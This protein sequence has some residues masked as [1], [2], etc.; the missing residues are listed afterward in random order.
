MTR[1]WLGAP[2]LLL[3]L[4]AAAAAQTPDSSARAVAS[5]TAVTQGMVYVGAGRNDGLREGA[6]VTVRRLGDRGRYRVTYL[7]S[8]SAACTPESGAE[9]PVVGDTV[10]FVPAAP[11]AGATGSR[12]GAGPESPARRRG[13]ALRG[14]VGVRYL[15]SADRGAGIGL[16]QPGL[17]LLLEGPVGPGSPVAISVDVRSRRTSTYRPGQPTLSNGLVGVYQAALRV[18]SAR[19]PFRAVLGRQYA[20]TLAG[21]GLFDGVLLD[22]QRPTWGAGVMAGL[23]PEL[24]T[25]A[26]SS[27]VRELG[28]FAQRRSAPGRPVRW[29]LTVGGVGSY[30]RSEVNREFAFLQ[31]TLGTRGVQAVV[32]QEL[33]FNRGWKLEAGESRLAATSTYFSLHLTPARWLSL[34]GGLDNRRN[35]RLYRD[36]TTPEELFDDR[37]RFGLWGGAAITAGKV[38]L[39]GD[40]R[41]STIGG[42]DSLRTTAVSTYLGVDR[43]TGAGLGLRLRATRYETPGRGPGQLYSGAVRIAPA[44]IGTL[45]LVGGSR[46]EDN[47]PSADRFWAG[48]NVE[49][50][51]RR[52]WF[53]LAS[54]SREWGRDGLTPTTDQL[55]AGIS[56]RF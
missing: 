25:L 40:V 33:D 49:L 11:E 3:G 16:R 4:A 43:L 21:V 41:S 10:V 46:R 5:V 20:P 50:A 32:L 6:L 34:N 27:E 23:A 53:G 52:A 1:L 51:L 30:V 9:L 26:V 29:S 15:S 28:L 19:G 54:F 56:Y 8:R 39:G 12:P 7:S 42:S 35:V 24:A 31:G 18:Q 47:S 48:A 13:Q 38:R 37:F 45:E 44:T 36:L 14:R 2:G 55:Y 17:E 22:V